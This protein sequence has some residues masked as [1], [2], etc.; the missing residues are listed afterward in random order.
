MFTSERWVFAYGHRD[1]AE[2]PYLA[3]PLTIVDLAF[4]LLLSS[5]GRPYVDSGRTIEQQ[6]RSYLTY[7]NVYPVE[8]ISGQNLHD[9]L[10]AELFDP[11]EMGS[12]GFYIN[13]E[14]K[15]RLSG[16]YHYDENKL[17]LIQAPVTSHFSRKPTIFSRGGG[18]LDS[19][20]ALLSTVGNY[21]N[22]CEMILQYG[23]FKGKQIMRPE[24]IELL[25]SD[26]IS[27]I[28]NRS[29]SL[30]G[31]GFGVGVNNRPNNGKTK[32]ISWTG[33]Y[34]TI[35]LIDYEKKLTAIFM[36]QHHPWGYLNIMGKF[37]TAVVEFDEN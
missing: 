7:V 3:I 10:K 2:C 30:T 9:F 26:Q 23:N 24:T 13:E 21:A 15:T 32:A 35:F 6:R 8:R 17:T 22:F 37:V 1:T 16:L 33:A 5:N 20:G 12:T 29:F 31:Y 14:D 25:I 28:D 36:T 4:I 27:G 34:N 11:L 19:I 18:M